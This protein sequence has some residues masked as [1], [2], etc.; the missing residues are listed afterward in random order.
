M[1]HIVELKCGKVMCF[2][3]F[4]IGVLFHLQVFLQ[5]VEKMHQMLEDNLLPMCNHN[6]DV[7]LCEC[8]P[9]KNALAAITI[10]G[11]KYMFLF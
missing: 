5:I 7:S 10:S 6:P 3:I 8:W 4:L 9:P 1:K 11:T 2:K